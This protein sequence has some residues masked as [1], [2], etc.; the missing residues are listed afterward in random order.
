M[1]PFLCRLPAGVA[2]VGEHDAAGQQARGIGRQEQGDRA[3]LVRLASMRPAP[4]E[5]L[6]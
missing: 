2:A 6:S 5:L 3:D 4:P 1:P